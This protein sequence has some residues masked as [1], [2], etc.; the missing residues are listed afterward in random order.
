MMS[1]LIWSAV[2]L[3]ALFS[4]AN[5]FAEGPVKLIPAGSI[6]TDGKETGLSQTE[7]VDCGRASAIVVSDS[8]NGRVLQYSIDNN[9]IVPLRE[10][11]FPQVSY[12]VRAR[13]NS[14]GEILVLDGKTRRI[15]RISTAGEFAG[16]IEI[17][18]APGSG[19]LVP[20]NFVVDGKDTL[21][22]LDVYSGRVILTGPEGNYLSEVAF[23]ARYGFISD[24]TVDASGTIYLVDGIEGKIYSAP[25]DARVVTLFAK[26]LKDYCDFPAGIAADEKGHIFVVDRNGSRIVV[27]GKDG[28]FQGQQLGMGWKEGLLRYPSQICLNNRGKAFIADSGNNRVQVFTV[29]E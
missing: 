22:V 24:M 12:P 17:S 23:P 9:S 1:S 18:G 16:F 5:A 10:F 4:Y 14:K 3:V 20:K 8:G 25:R 11:R 7:G 2:T 15:A 13:W 28:S 21:Y 27:L 26:G 29:S 19:T 6:Y